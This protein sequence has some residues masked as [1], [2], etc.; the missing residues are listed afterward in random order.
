MK[1]LLFL[2]VAIFCTTISSGQVQSGEIIYKVKPP[3]EFKEFA[4]TTNGPIKD[5]RIRDFFVRQYE[6]Y[7]IAAPY[8]SFRLEFNEEEA[9]F[10]RVESMAND[11]GI[12]MNG[13]AIMAGVAGVYY[14]NFKKYFCLH[15]S[16]PFRKLVRVKSVFNDFDWC[17]SKEFK[18][19]AGYKCQKATTTETLYND[20]KIEIIAWFCPDLPFRFGPMNY[21]GLP[22]LILGLEKNNKYLYADNISLSE[23]PETIKMPTKGTLM[24]KEVFDKKS[25]ENYKRAM[26]HYES[27]K[28]K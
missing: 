22:G 15:Q 16:E 4:D 3:Q 6:K 12:D 25:L 19:I 18:T 11:N 5:Q 13:M 2:I 9:L 27:I 23:T 10:S 7:K 14:C 20:K 26:E 17:I 24:A 21:A 8:L 28:N 1:N